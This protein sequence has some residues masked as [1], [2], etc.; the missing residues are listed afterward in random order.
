MVDTRTP[1]TAGA[2]APDPGLVAALTGAAGDADRALAMRTRRSVYNAAKNS[3]AER[4]EG[5]RNLLIALVTAVVLAMMLLPA[6]WSG[7]EEMVSGAAL[8]DLP[9]MLAAFGIMLFAAMTAALFL[10]GDDRRASHGA[11]HTRR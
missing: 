5:K 6:I 1:L 3:R 2:Q 8:T 10:L 7:V 11:R 9:V 4:A